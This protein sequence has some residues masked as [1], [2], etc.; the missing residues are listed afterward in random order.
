[1]I[2][3]KALEAVDRTLRDV[4]QNDDIM[5]GLLFVLSGDFRQILPVI[6]R[7]TRAN[8]VHSCL[9]SSVLWCSVETHYLTTNMRARTSSLDT[10]TTQHFSEQLLR[11]GNGDTQTADNKDIQI[12]P[13]LAVLA[14]T[15]QQ[16]R[17][18]IYPELS[19]H[20]TDSDW[21]CQ[22]AILAPH[23]ETV[24]AINNRLLDE[25]PGEHSQFLSIDTALSDEES[26]MYPTEFLNTIEVSGFPPYVLN[27]KIGAPV[28]LIRNISPPQLCN[29]TRCVVRRL[30][31]NCVELNVVTG[32]AKGTTAFLP[33]IPL[34]TSNV[35]D[36]TMA[37]QFR[38]LQ[39]PLKLS[40]AMT[41]NKSQGKTLQKAGL[42]L[43]H[44]CFSHG[45]FYVAVSRVGSKENLSIFCCGGVIHNVVYKEVL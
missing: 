37:F 10:E 20:A 39:F 32:P 36:P 5:G 8:E 6:P 1:M 25:F 22:R 41:V 23:N 35:D 7:G 43:E 34:T 21:L 19:A 11:I 24:N 12:T 13:E 17:D 38:R 14:E 33:R 2:H 16:L 45:Q 9:K 28:I 18:E 29:G 3:K 42:H 26:T 44:P 15:P 30:T 40:F 27:L 31:T 4:R